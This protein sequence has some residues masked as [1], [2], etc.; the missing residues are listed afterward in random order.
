MRLTT[1][2]RYAVTAMLDLAIHAGKGPVSL[3]DISE[4]Q[5]ISLSYLEQLFAKLRRNELVR[6]VRGPGGGYQLNREQQDIDVA[7]V[8]DAVNESVD[9]T[10]CGHTGSCHDG[11]VCLTHHLWCDLSSQIH[12]F[13]SQISLADLMERNDVRS[14]AERQGRVHIAPFEDSRISAKVTA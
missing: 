5:G 6:S 2:G 11:N 4:R 1:K 12:D 14:V 13:L 9:A 8:I 3:A 7:Q 10:G